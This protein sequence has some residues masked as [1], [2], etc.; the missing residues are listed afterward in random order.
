M[1]KYL[2]TSYSNDIQ[3]NIILLLLLLL[4]ISYVAAGPRWGMVKRGGYN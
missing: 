2:M 4:D 1:L 3:K